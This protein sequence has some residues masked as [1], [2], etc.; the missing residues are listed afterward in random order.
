MGVIPFHSNPRIPSRRLACWL[1][2]FLICAALCSG[3]LR[4]QQEALQDTQQDPLA[5]LPESKHLAAALADKASRG[6]T[7]L[8]LAAV[9]QMLT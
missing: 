8:T 4:A 7:L 1:G 6:D 5:D 3:P 2:P 9:A